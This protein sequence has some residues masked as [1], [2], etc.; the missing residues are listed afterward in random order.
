MAHSSFLTP[1]LSPKLSPD[2]PPVPPRASPTTTDNPRCPLDQILVLYHKAT[3]AYLLRQLAS[4]Y[5]TTLDALDLLSTT[6]QHHALDHSDNLSTRRSYYILKQK[7]W[8]L[9]T[10]VFGS[11]LSDR[12]AATA[13]AADGTH[14]P[15]LHKHH[16]RPPSDSGRG[17]ISGI[18]KR[19]SGSSKESP[20]KL[21]KEMWRR[22]VDDYGGLEGDVDGQVMVI[23]TLLC[24]DQKLYPLA[25]QIVEAYLATIPEGMLIHLETAAGV[26]ISRGE[27]G[28]KDPLITN[29]ERLMELYLLH[30]LTKLDEWEY[31]ADLVQY[32]SVLSDHTKQTYSKILD[33]LH[34]RS[35]RPKK[36]TKHV[37]RPFLDA[38]DDGSRSLSRSGSTTVASTT[39]PSPTLSSTSAMDVVNG[40]HALDTKSV[41]GSQDSVITPGKSTPSTTS[42]STQKV[43]VAKK[44]S[45]RASSVST[46]NKMLLVLQHYGNLIKSAPSRMG[47]NHIMIVVGLVIFLTAISRNRDRVSKYLKAG[48]VKV[49]QTVKMGTT[50]TSI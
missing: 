18:R 20:E 8:M 42:P 1:P 24:I 3:S 46:Q 17:L 43:T 2:S 41:V 48:M 22:L 36:R 13:V 47:S 49:M 4:A 7:L 11:M 25:R 40:T 9:H 31:V 37:R 26:A 6:N 35:Q 39:P 50:V 14:P 38:M 32:N 34:Q 21:V 27:H 45:A 19:I 5:S 10:T 44:D 23:L 30:V 15:H 16:H 29:Y 12:A 28:E 33:K